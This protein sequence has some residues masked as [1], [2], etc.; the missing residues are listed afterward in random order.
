MPKNRQNPDNR[1]FQP[2][3]LA[4]VMV[5]GIL[6]YWLAF[7]SQPSLLGFQGEDGSTLPRWLDLSMLLLFDELVAGISGHGRLET[8]IL[9]RLPIVM[10]GAAWLALSRVIGYPWVMLTGL[11]RRLSNIEVQTL[12]VLTGLAVLSTLTLLVGL[13]AGFQT[14]WPML[15]GV[16][17]LTALSWMMQRWLGRGAPRDS[18]RNAARKSLSK[19]TGGVPTLEPLFGLPLQATPATNLGSLWLQRLLPAAVCGLG[20]LYF[21][22]CLITPYEFDVV[23]YHLQ[24]PK[25]FA[26]AGKIAFVPHNIYANMPLGAE[27]HSLAIMALIGQPIRDAW[28]WGGLVGKFIIGSFSLIAAL[29]LG[30]FIARK[31]GK[32]AG[33]SAAGLLLSA[34]GNAFVTNAGLIDS[35]VGA[36]LLA[37]LVIWSTRWPLENLFGCV[38]LASLFAGATA[39]CKYP[40]VVFAIAPLAL[41]TFVWMWHQRLSSR[42]KLH[43]LAAGCLGLSLTCLPWLAKNALLAHNPVYPLAANLFGGRELDPERIAQWQ[44]AHAV[45]STAGSKYGATALLTSTRQLFLESPFLSP[46]LIALTAA[47]LTVA[48]LIL[49]GWLRVSTPEQSTPAQSTSAES[50]SEKSTP[51][52]STPERL[53]AGLYQRVGWCGSWAGLAIWILLVWW[54]AT[55]RIDRFWLPVVPIYAGLAALGIAWIARWLSPSL[56]TIFVLV[57]VGYGAFIN[58]SGALGDNRFLV[59]LNALRYDAGDEEL[60]GRMSPSVLWVNENLNSPTDKVLL[61]GEARVFDFLPPIEY[62]TC[63]NENPAEPRL[64]GK[65]KEE[66]RAN[67]RAAQISHLLINWSEIARYRSPGNYGFSDWPQRSDIDQLLADGIVERV[68]WPFETMRAELLK[69]LP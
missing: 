69:V 9:D 13:S 34:P 53:S 37:M 17:G 21:L 63:F 55:H 61:I 5:V 54:L 16:A 42:H 20:L 2:R 23:E 19:T 14:R 11:L 30:G 56:A 38:A 68:A 43:A 35:V 28:W 49:C 46:S 40:G 33:W 3:L 29:L 41:A 65:T 57:S 58:L 1:T 22:S 24:A 47:G 6:L 60:A 36:Y 67:L 4:A 52:Q 8:G 50:T 44:A 39:A 26:A 31:F 51:A 64:R 45:P 7:F 12:S 59:S 27:M 62:A 18:A 32:L 48:G 15:G 66:Q 10:A 25:E